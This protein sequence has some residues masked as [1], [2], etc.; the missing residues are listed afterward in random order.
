[1][2]YFTCPNSSIT[3]EQSQF[4]TRCNRLVSSRW[5]NTLQSG[6]GSFIEASYLFTSK[7][8]L[9]I[10][11]TIFIISLVAA[12]TRNLAPT[13]PKPPSTETPSSAIAPTAAVGQDI[14]FHGENQLAIKGL[15]YPAPQTPAPTVL[16]LNFRN[17]WGNWAGQ[18][19]AR[20]FNVIAI[21]LLMYNVGG[22]LEAI[23][24]QDIADIQLVINQL[25]RNPA[26]MPHR[27]ALVG[28]SLMGGYALE[29][30]ALT[31]DCKTAVLLSPTD[32]AIDILDPMATYGSRPIL[33]TA[34]KGEGEIAL[35]AQKWDQEA[36]GDHQLLLY[37]WGFHATAMFDA[38]PE[39]V[40]TVGDWF[41]KY[42]ST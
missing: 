6:M 12:F 28:G 8:N 29:S 15:L 27:V 34:S 22:S 9:L 41:V 11:V 3:I 36:R 16:L 10:F 32:T 33:I 38:H 31:P 37:D 20:G 24:K 25:N 13:T 39:L 35:T 42:L 23:N 5:M 30:C 14:T 7:R 1:M 40:T 21:D 19:S 26:M 17:Q 2:P 18:W 4:S